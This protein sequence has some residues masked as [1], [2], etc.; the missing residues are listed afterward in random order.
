MYEKI[1]VKIANNTCGDEERISACWINH[2]TY[3]P[4]EHPKHIFGPN[5][6]VPGYHEWPNYEIERTMDIINSLANKKKYRI[7][8]IDSLTR[9][10]D[11][12]VPGLAI[13]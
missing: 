5:P 3:Y 7:I 11:V 9:R 12:K 1:D 6:K 10:V 4:F 2:P 8:E 13:F